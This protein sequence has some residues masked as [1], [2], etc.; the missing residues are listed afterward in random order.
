MVWLTQNRQKSP[1]SLWVGGSGSAA[2]AN[3]MALLAPVI[4]S[5]VG[6]CLELDKELGKGHPQGMCQLVGGR[7]CDG[8]LTA[9]N[10]TNV[11]TM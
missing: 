11:G 2:L 4:I 8:L 3:I 9:L 1:L 10:R 7:N 5:N 6:W